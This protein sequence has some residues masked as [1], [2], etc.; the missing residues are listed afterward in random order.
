DREKLFRIGGLPMEKFTDKRGRIYSLKD[1]KRLNPLVFQRLPAKIVIPTAIVKKD[2]VIK[3]TT[4]EKVIEETVTDENFTNT[5]TAKWNIPA[6]VGSRPEFIRIMKEHQ[7]VTIT[8]VPKK[9]A[10]AVGGY[11]VN[12]PR[13]YS[14]SNPY[15]RNTWRHEMGHIIDVNIGRLRGGTYISSF[16][17]FKGAMAADVKVMKMTQGKGRASKAR[18]ALLKA[19]YKDQTH[20]AWKIGDIEDPRVRINALEEFAENAGFNFQKFDSWIRTETVFYQSGEDL[21]QIHE[22][23]AK[24]LVSMKHK[25]PH[26]FVDA[27]SKGWSDKVLDPR[28]FNLANEKTG[29][30]ASFSDLIGSSSKNVVLDHHAR[31]YGHTTAYLKKYRHRPATES[32][33]NLNALFGNK[34]KYWWDTIA[35]TFAPEMAKT[36]ENIIK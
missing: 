6:S 11:N 33:A 26:N 19:K 18:D 21:A 1:L 8:A 17:A 30:L 9:G 24:V 2:P 31:Y 25:A 10:Y 20:F 32:F 28:M 27:M 29:A 14:P 13:S 22:R 16:P 15:N 3:P 4:T 35:K 34:N 5:V 12:M 23:M 36:Y 7:D